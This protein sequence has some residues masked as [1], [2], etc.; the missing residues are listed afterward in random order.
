MF[1]A[2][3]ADIDL[4]GLD[5]VNQCC[6]DKQSPRPSSVMGKGSQ[7]EKI[8]ES[9]LDVQRG[10]P[11]FPGRIDGLKEEAYCWWSLRNSKGILEPV[12]NL[13]QKLGHMPFV[14]D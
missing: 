7:K 6:G 11:S 5:Q 9:S 14:D 2:H 10:C 1:R 4:N 8:L 12:G 3:D 13:L